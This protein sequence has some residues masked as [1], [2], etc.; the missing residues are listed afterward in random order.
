MEPQLNPA[1]PRWHGTRHRQL[2]R[3]TA[4]ATAV[5]PDQEVRRDATAGGRRVGACSATYRT[6]SSWTGGFQGEVTVTAGSSAINGWT[7]R[8]ILNNGQGITGS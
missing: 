2:H 7:V 1:G 5:A 4:A 6:V 8:W 3:T